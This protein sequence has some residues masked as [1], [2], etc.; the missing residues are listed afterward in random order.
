M[1][2]HLLLGVGLVRELIVLHRARESD[3]RLDRIALLPNVTVEALLV[4][5]GF[6]ARAGEHHR[7]GLAADLVARE[8]LEM[9]DHDL[10]L[11]DD[12]VRVQA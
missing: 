4:A 12:I 5:Y 6:Q 8:R 1:P 10:G 3:Q 11:L 7:L 9:L 2:F